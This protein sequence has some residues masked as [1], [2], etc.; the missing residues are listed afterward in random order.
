MCYINMII[1][2]NQR[3]T[4]GVALGMGVFIANVS[5]P[6][7]TGQVMFTYVKRSQRSNFC[8]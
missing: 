6:F 4:G 7:F 1:L 5:G 2:S 3:L 8:W